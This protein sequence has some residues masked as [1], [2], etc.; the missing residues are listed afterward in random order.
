MNK[1]T[2]EL[3]PE[4]FNKNSLVY[5]CDDN[6]SVKL[7]RETNIKEFEDYCLLLKKT[8]YTLFDETDINGNIHKTYLSDD[9]KVKVY[10]TPC[11]KCVRIVAD[12]NNTLYCNKA[13]DFKKTCCA[14]F[15]QFETDHTLIDCGMC[16]IFRCSD[17]RFFIIDSAHFYSVNDNEKLYDFLRSLTPKNQKII[18][19]G[20]FFTHG[21]T[22]HICKF[23]DFIRFNMK[24]VIIENIYYNFPFN[25]HPDS[26]YWD[27]SE[28]NTVNNFRFLLKNFDSINIIT[29]HTGDRYY[30][31]DLCI[32]VLCTHEDVYPN[33][34]KNYNDSSSVIL[35]HSN[36]NKIL[37]PGDAG[38]EVEKVLSERYGEYL[39]CDILQVAHHGHFG[40]SEKFY[41]TV[42]APVVLF[43]TTRIKYD[44]EF[45]HYEAN[46]VAVKLAKEVYISSDGTV[47]FPV[48]YKPGNAEIFPDE[49]FEDFSGI[50]NL[51]G[52][53]YTDERK[54]ELRQEFIKRG[55]SNE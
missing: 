55:K 30:L 26:V 1:F 34:L 43:P 5:E 10:F 53:T 2:V 31:A 8:G 49:T 14:K 11:D 47:G 36:N 20:W 37:I 50:Y 35:L 23:T 9:M 3:L 29:V 16:Y 17:N 48:P 18:I 27:T 38:A 42:N 25:N 51:W 40:C 33:S 32:E 44:E 41:K 21:H 15:Y 46:R 39:K 13:E 19:G 7:C 22:D 12:K 6:S 45:E 24:D 28:K 4:Y 52:Y 54:E